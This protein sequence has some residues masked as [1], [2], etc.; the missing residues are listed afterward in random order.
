[1]LTLI[2]SSILVLLFTVI[3]LFHFYW[4]FGGTWGLKN[5]IPTKEDHLQS[6]AIPKF[7]TLLVAI[8]FLAFGA[9]YAVKSGMLNYSL[10]NWVVN[11][12]YWGIAI[13]FTLRAIGDFNYLGFFKK[14]THTDFAKSDTKLFSPLC[15]SIGIIAF[16]LQLL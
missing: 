14:I 3:S 4:F 7:A 6:L 11:Y 2:L 12:G 8:V 1:M 16:I 9:I 10:P 5:V 13:I 15:L